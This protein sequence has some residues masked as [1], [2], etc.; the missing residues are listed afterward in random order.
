MS[1]THP[2]LRAQTFTTSGTATIDARLNA[3]SFDLVATEPGAEA[4]AA[5]SSGAVPLGAHE[6]RV[7]IEASGGR[8][9]EMISRCVME[10]RGDTVH[11]VVPKAATFFGAFTTVAVRVHAPAGSDLRVHSGSGDVVA[12]GRLGRTEV[13]GGSGDVRLELAT[14]IEVR[15]GSGSVDLGT[16]DDVSVRSGSGRIRV[17]HIHSMG[18]LSA[19]SGGVEVDRAQGS[20]TVT[21]GS[22]SVVVRDF[23]GEANLR[24][25]SGRLIIERAV[26]GQITLGSGSGSV[27]IGIPAG[28]AAHLDVSTGSGGVHSD[29][30]PAQDGPGEDRTLFVRGRTGSGSVRIERAI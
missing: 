28:T 26:E 25:G 30:G 14:S 8:A 20:L 11:I 13:R 4:A 5:T 15:A 7:E 29:L 6:V 17:D 18:R 1:T 9:E 19:G 3:A 10:Q 2:T 16:G 27:R 22:G 21:S 23:A 12:M 24:V